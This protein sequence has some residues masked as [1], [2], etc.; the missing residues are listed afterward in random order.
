MPDQSER[1]LQIEGLFNLRDLGGYACAGGATTRWRALLRADGL[2][3]MTPESCKM[4]A[5]LG[6]TTIIDLRGAHETTRHPGPFVAYPG[7]AY[8][9]IPLFDALA[10]V[11]GP[12]EDFDMAQ[13]YRDG[14]DQCGLRIA[15]VL[16]TIAEA[17]DGA[18]LFHCTAGKDRTGIIAALLLLNA[19]VPEDVIVADYALTATLAAPLLKE[20]GEA[21]LSMGASPAAVARMLASD[22][23]TMAA[24]IEHLCKT[25]GDIEA[26]GRAIGLAPETPARLRARLVESGL[27]DQMIGLPPVTAMV[28]PEI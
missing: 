16:E 26:F 7:I 1:H 8:R 19:G 13:R 15:E 9:N 28:A 12:A 20:L 4:L 18:V 24:F 23:A 6:V 21:A 17:S 2:H 10:P 11:A 27:A 5:A 22:P 3:R 25:Y 14:L